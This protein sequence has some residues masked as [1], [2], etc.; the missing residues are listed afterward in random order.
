MDSVFTPVYHVFFP[1]LWPVGK[2][3]V[4]YFSFQWQWTVGKRLLSS[5][6]T[7]PTASWCPLWTAV[8]LRLRLREKQLFRW[9]N[10]HVDTCTDVEAGMC[11]QFVVGLHFL[12]CIS[13]ISSSPSFSFYPSFSPSF[14]P[15]TKGVFLFKGPQKPSGTQSINC[16]NWWRRGEAFGT[17]KSH[18]LDRR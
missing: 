12:T 7:N 11:M 5:W 17:S 14:S 16:Y 3:D 10:E 4:T 6:V 1:K 9:I 18:I 15:V 2:F 8:P 13:P